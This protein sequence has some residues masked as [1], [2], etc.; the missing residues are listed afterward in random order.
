MIV[1]VDPGKQKPQGKKRQGGAPRA[2]APVA[3]NAGNNN[4]VV[5][6]VQPDAMVTSEDAAE[7][8]D[9]LTYHTVKDWTVEEVGDKFLVPIG[10]GKLRPLFSKH[11]VSGRVLS[12]L[13]KEDLKDMQIISVG[14][15]VFLN[16]MIK[17][18]RK[19][20]KRHLREEIV[21][22]GHYPPPTGGIQYFSDFKSC[23][24]YKCCPCCS[25]SKT[26]EFTRQGLRE[27]TNPPSCVVCCS[28]TYN[29][30]HDIRFM[31]DLDWEHML[32]LC[33]TLKRKEM[34]FIFLED[35]QSELGDGQFEPK[36][37]TIA[38]PDV[39]EELVN[40]IAFVWGESR[41]VAGAI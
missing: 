24:T 37:V 2:R 1:F 11:K 14:D 20:Y 28:T 18:L 38:H 19:S 29:D 22:R 15:R 6:D 16:T 36:N 23:L 40:K 30:F 17:L 7:Y 34:T 21:W 26:Y 3:T 32:M 9:T 27:R 33:G 4:E 12:K 41:L 35:G 25:Y 5:V 39:T 10:M 13:E 31:K 8:I